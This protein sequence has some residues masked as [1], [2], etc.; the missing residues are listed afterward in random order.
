M[1]FK[2]TYLYSFIL[3]MTSILLC[4]SISLAQSTDV[5]ILNN[6]DKITGE[7]KY[8]QVGIL[9]FKT[10]NMETINIQWDKIRSLETKNFYELELQ[11]GRQYFGSIEPSDEEGMI[12]VKGVT[13]DSKL[14]MKYIVRIN[15]IKE[16][17][18]DI[19]DGYIKFG[20]SFTKASE[21]GELSFGVNAKYRTKINYSELN[22][23]SV[24]TTT[25][26]EP[27]SRKQDITYSF[28]HNLEYQW[29][30]AGLVSLEENTELGIKLRAS[31][32]GGIGGNFIQSAHHWLYSLAGL[33]VNRELKTDN[34]AGTT[35]LEGLINAQYQL[36]KYDHPKAN[37]LTYIYL[38]PGL[39]DLGR[40]RLNYNIQL[41]WEIFLDFYW[42]LTFYFEYDNSPQTESATQSDYRIDTSIKFEF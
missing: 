8:L 19:L 14:F 15:R 23:N 9:T 11:D 18:W 2:A 22:L 38:F 7:I 26:Y 6:G 20:F 35:N 40:F 28:Q 33:S 1:N 31:L 30:G 3:I 29:F 32:G 42:D 39:S 36:F 12:V 5:V 41:S 10:D 25:S 13:L 21:I 17:F 27:T 16:S 37:L 34:T 24:L 4:N